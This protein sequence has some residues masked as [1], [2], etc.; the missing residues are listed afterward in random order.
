MEQEPIDTGQSEQTEAREMES[1]LFIDE[2]EHVVDV[3]DEKIQKEIVEARNLFHE[4]WREYVDKFDLS[5][6]A[7]IDS[8][9]EAAKEKGI[10]EAA[11]KIRNL[12]Y[13]KNISIYGVSYLSNVCNQN[14]GFCPQGVCN[15]EVFLTQQ[16][17]DNNPNMSPKEKAEKQAKID[18]YKAK[19]KTLSIDEAKQD[20]AALAEIG[21][22]EICVL[23]GEDI[24]A[25]PD[26]VIDYI[27][28]ALD[29]PGIK[30][31]IL[32]LGS[33]S[34]KI[35]KMIKENLVIPEGKKLQH[36]VFQETYDPY[37]YDRFV[38]YAPKESTVDQPSKRYWIERH[39]SQA[40]ALRAG[41]GEVGIGALFGLTKNP[42]KEIKG[43]Q[44]HAI[45]IKKLHGKEPKRCCLP[46]GNEPEYTHVD[47]PYMIPTRPKA[48]EIAELI[49][50]LARLALPTVSI[51]SSERDEP[52]LLKKLDK[53]ANHT[54]L[55]VHPGPGRNTESLK[56][57]NTVEKTKS[58]VVEQAKTTARQPRQ[59]IL[60]WLGRGYHILD[61]D[62]QKYLTPD[63]MEQYNL[64]N[65]Q[66][67]EI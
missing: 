50:A 41:F 34:A 24:T 14:C 5:N 25:Q 8:T 61:F 11:E 62:W 7:S 36:R 22:Q 18:A 1:V 47:I 53:Y 39:M 13:D 35:F 17:I 16:E 44:D 2:H 33:Y 21:H 66:T 55:F 27:Q 37:E 57:L 52:E 29:T 32:N 28:L 3:D 45:S 38:K 6:E 48:A 42:L 31:V 15:L 54:T 65:Q 49:Y 9:L 58:S 30:E 59:A 67:F 64:Q 10:F 19:L 40:Q 12:I 60:D 63:E 51:V 23:S 56:E 4:F 26:K 43:L 46:L 20:F